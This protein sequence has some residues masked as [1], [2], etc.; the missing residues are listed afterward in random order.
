MKVNADSFSVLV[1]AKSGRLNVLFKSPLWCLCSLWVG[2]LNVFYFIINIKIKY[3]ISV[4]VLQDIRIMFSN[5][6]Q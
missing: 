4:M 6:E 3:P 1:L 5:D 2:S